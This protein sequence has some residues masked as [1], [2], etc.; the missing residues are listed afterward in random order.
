[1]AAIAARA[2]RGPAKLRDPEYREESKRP[3]L[4]ALRAARLRAMGLRVATGLPLKAPGPP[5]FSASV[6]EPGQRVAA[7][8]PQVVAVVCLPVVDV[9]VKWQP[10]ATRR[11]ARSIVCQA[12]RG[13]RKEC[14]S[15]LVS[16]SS[17][18]APVTDLQ[19]PRAH[20]FGRLR[21]LAIARVCG[22]PL[23]KTG[24]TAV[25]QDCRRVPQLAVMQLRGYVEQVVR[26]VAEA[27]PLRWVSV[28]L[29]RAAQQAGR[30][31]YSSLAADPVQ[32]L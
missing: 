13:G 4:A 12:R 5:L 8:H 3:L 31:P 29:R 19:R 30:S 17:R 32:I 28:A 7:V 25:K 14:G 26:V 24:A 21:R 11:A 10:E 18:A 27:A 1:V 6:K 23:A 22:T 2:D 20:R 9:H 16:P 15:K